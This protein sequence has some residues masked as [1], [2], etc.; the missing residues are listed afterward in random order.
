MRPFQTA[1][2]REF[3]EAYQRG[4]LSYTY[5]GVPCLKSPIDLAIYLSLLWN[6]KPRT[7][8]EIGSKEGG[9]ALLFHDVAAAFELGATV[10]SIDL[11]KPA[12]P[13]PGDVRFLEG[14]V[15][16]LDA[17]FEEH[18]LFSLPRPWLVVED[19]AHTYSACLAALEF[20]R[21]HLRPGELLVIEDGVLAELGLSEDY[22]G[23]PNRAIAD[24]F[25]RWPRAFEV[26]TGYCDM[27]GTNATYNPNGYLRRSPPASSDSTPSDPERR[28]AGRRRPHARG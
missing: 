18:G 1:F 23:G 12:N 13:P 24:F 27:F 5:K 9:S 11:E 3:L 16:N 17:V 21:R 20:F 6:E 14:D 25:V 15:T 8:L 10:V 2:S 19:S 28:T 22:D 4:S 26:V 7:I